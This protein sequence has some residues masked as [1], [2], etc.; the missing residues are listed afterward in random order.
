MEISLSITLET[1]ARRKRPYFA[2]AKEEALAK[3]GNL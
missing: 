1:E 3:K 2:L